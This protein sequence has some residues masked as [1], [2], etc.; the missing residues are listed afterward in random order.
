VRKARKIK[1]NLGY[2]KAARKLNPGWTNP[3]MKKKVGRR[4]HE[5]R[6]DYPPH[7]EDLQRG[8]FPCT[9]EKKGEGVTERLKPGL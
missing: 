3:A 7:E 4:Y 5:Q 6:Q 1:S 2:E 9:H 8:S